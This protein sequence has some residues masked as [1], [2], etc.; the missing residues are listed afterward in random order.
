[1]SGTDDASEPIRQRLDPDTAA[2][3]ERLKAMPVA[4]LHLCTPE[5]ARERHERTAASIQAPVEP[6][7]RVADSVIGG[8]PVRVYRP[9][10]AK[11]VSVFVHGGG[12]VTG[13]LDSYDRLARALANRSATQFIS[14]D[15][16]LAP[17]AKHPVQL[18]QAFAV[19]RSVIGD[20]GSPVVLA[21]DSAG[22]YLA[23]LAALR[24]RDEGLRLGGLALINPV[25]DPALD[26]PSSRL[27]AEGYRLETE[28]MRWYW[29][30]FLEAGE[31]APRLLGRDLSGLPDTLVV[32]AGFDPLHDEGAEFARR[33]GVD[34][35]PIEYHDYPGQVH[36]FLRLSHAI[37]EG[38]DAQDVV[39]RFIRRHA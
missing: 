11:G 4:P 9:R 1:M 31:N 3:L 30:H 16:A 28:A 39:G 25:I 8:I 13:S 33:L 19:L 10:D 32:T 14:V 37:R 23:A 21:G 17:E 36:G 12:W 38:R 35:V 18:D 5:E 22:G 24:A 26:T 29:R 6:V 7:E 20:A 27:H 2:Y 15:Y 34:R